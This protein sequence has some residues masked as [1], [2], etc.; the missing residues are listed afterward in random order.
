MTLLVGTKLVMSADTN[1]DTNMA[2]RMRFQDS[3]TKMSLNPTALKLTAPTAQVCTKAS[4]PAIRPAFGLD[5]ATT[6]TAIT[7]F[8]LS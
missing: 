8:G 3:L 6:S 7:A 1:T 5:L 2:I 4:M